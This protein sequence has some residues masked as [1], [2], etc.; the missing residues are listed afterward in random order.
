MADSIM[1]KYCVW[2][3]DKLKQFKDNKTLNN[4]WVQLLLLSPFS[5]FFYGYNLHGC[6][7]IPSFSLLPTIPEKVV[8]KTRQKFNYSFL[9]CNYKLFFC[10]YKTFLP[11]C[12]WDNEYTTVFLYQVKKLYSLKIFHKTA[13]FSVLMLF[14]KKLCLTLHLIWDIQLTNYKK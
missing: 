8:I 10:N 3:V 2:S 4:W 7:S 9:F 13:F 6:S 12:F 1:F 14:I 11:L 5:E